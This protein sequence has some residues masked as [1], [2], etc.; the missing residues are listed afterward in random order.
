VEKV[1]INKMKMNLEVETVQFEG[2]SR[3]VEG[4]NREILL[5]NTGEGQGR[6]K[7]GARHCRKAKF[8]PS[9]WPPLVRSPVASLI[10]GGGQY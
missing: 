6:G 1:G 2:Q 5:L 7:R 4:G 10:M 8:K 3:Q 9:V